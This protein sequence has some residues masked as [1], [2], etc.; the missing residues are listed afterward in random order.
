M[1]QEIVDIII[2]GGGPEPGFSPPF[3]R[4]YVKRLLKLLKPL[5]PLVRNSGMLFILEKDGLRHP[6]LPEIGLGI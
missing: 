6:C 4:A 5:P 3:T 1:T 2:I